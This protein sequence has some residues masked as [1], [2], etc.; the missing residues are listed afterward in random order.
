MT[1]FRLYSVTALLA[2]SLAANVFAATADAPPAD[3]GLPEHGMHGPHDGF[4]DHGPGM[5]GPDRPFGHLHGMHRLNLTE[6]Q[7]DKLFALEHA[8]APQR[9]EQGKAIRHA[10]DT[11]RD[12]GRADRFDEARAGAA[13]RDLGQAVGAQA[14]AHARLRAQ[15]LAVLTPEQREQLKRTRP[16][17]GPEADE[18]PR[19][20]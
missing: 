16:G 10:Q 14:L 20:P 15:M 2:A 4:G 1:T 3:T 18:A 11:L 19:H 12:L 7:Q 8:A 13:A 17:A 9:R 6:A 5:P